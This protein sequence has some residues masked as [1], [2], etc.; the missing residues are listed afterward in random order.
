MV[1]VAA[2]I[3]LFC[4]WT[5]WGWFVTDRRE[6]LWAR[7]WCATM[8]VASAILISLGAGAVT[9][10]VVVKGRHRAQVQEF[11]T[12]LEQH[13]SAGHTDIARKELKRIIEEP[14]EWS[15]DSEDLLKRMTASTERLVSGQM[16]NSTESLPVPAEPESRP[17]AA[18]NPVRREA[19]NRRAPA[20]QS[21]AR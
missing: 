16:T 14:D 7:N 13:L 15:A 5:L 20:Q 1:L 19:T 2:L 17:R 8:F 4:A 9:T 21:T 3:L 11:A 6:I 12:V 10:L 18:A